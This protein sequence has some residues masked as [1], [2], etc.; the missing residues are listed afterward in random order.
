MY[1][2]GLLA[3][4]PK[5]GTPEHNLWLAQCRK[6]I[7]DRVG[8]VWNTSELQDDFKIDGFMAPLC[9]GVHKE[10]GVKITLAFTHSPR[11]YYGMREM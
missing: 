9:Y 11:F 3:V 6:E 5:Y 1:S 2:K 4:E 10:T 8:Q 7:E